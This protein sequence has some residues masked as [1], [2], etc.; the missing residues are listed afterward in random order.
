MGELGRPRERISAVSFLRACT[1]VEAVPYRETGWEGLEPRKERGMRS[2]KGLRF[3]AVSAGTAAILLAFTGT[4]SAAVAW[5]NAS[6][7]NAGFGWSGGQNNIDPVTGPGFGTPTVY[8]WGFDF[9]NPVNFRSEGGGGVGDTTEDFAR[10]TMDRALSTPAGAPAFHFIR[11]REWGTYDLG[12]Y[13]G[14]PTAYL[15]V[16]ADFSVF[17]FSPTPLGNTGPVIISS[18]SAPPVFTPYDAQAPENGG[19]WYAD[20]ILVAGEVGNPPYANL[21]WNKFQI[22]V[23][24]AIQVD[25]TAPA[26]SFIDKTG[27]QIITP[28]PGSVLLLVAGMGSLMLRR[29]RRA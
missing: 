22:T 26:G 2:R 20:R 15:T 25:G 5:G 19:T 24:N 12:D 6:G 3:V 21:D 23:T 14:D 28:E 17:R 1:A 27:M 16:Q 29:S 11:V 13:T 9:A 18:T 8:T 4:A 10:V 7:S